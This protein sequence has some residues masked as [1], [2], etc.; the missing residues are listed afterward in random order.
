M[1]NIGYSNGK[2]EKIL[3]K[4]FTYTIDNINN[5]S[6]EENI[7]AGNPIFIKDS[8]DIIGIAKE[9]KKNCNEY[10]ADFI[11]IINNRIYYKFY[12]ISHSCIESCF[13]YT[14]IC[15]M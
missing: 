7:R 8:I 13:T 2:I 1:S 11:E 9:I 5:I 10:Y 14:I 12:W 4:E 15:I 6:K 3:D